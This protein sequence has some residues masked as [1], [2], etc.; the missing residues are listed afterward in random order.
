[1]AENNEKTLIS[2]VTNVFFIIQ[3]QSLFIMQS[4]LQSG[5]GVVQVELKN[6]SYL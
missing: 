1:M 5:N 6:D 2:H 4:T 3:K